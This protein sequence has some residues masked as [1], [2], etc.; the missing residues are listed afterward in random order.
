V[1]TIDEDPISGSSGTLEEAASNESCGSDV[2]DLTGRLNRPP[3]EKTEDENEKMDDA[4]ADMLAR[5]GRTVVRCDL[6]GLV[7]ILGFPLATAADEVF[8]AYR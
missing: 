8:A 2:E 1:A 3:T 5:W 6:V 7:P 4:L